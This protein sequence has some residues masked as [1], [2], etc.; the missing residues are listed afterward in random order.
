[1]RGAV[2][3]AGGAN[4]RDDSSLATLDGIGKSSADEGRFGELF[5]CAAV[6]E[7]A[8]GVSELRRVVDMDPTTKGSSL[9][10]S[11]VI[12]AAAAESL[13]VLLVFLDSRVLAQCAVSCIIF[14]YVLSSTLKR[15][16]IGNTEHSS[17][18]GHMRMLTYPAARNL[19]RPH[20]SS[21]SSSTVFM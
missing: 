17:Q 16:V 3:L 15:K 11:F 5:C 20:M 7:R 8:I 12:I 4:G 19:K 10:S 6:D 18:N 9:D 21:A 13:R 2:G 1:M 14:R